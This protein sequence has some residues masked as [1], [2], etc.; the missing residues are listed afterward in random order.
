MKRCLLMSKKCRIFIGC[1][2]K[3]IEIAKKLRKALNE[4]N[5]ACSEIFDQG[6]FELSKTTIEN[7]EDNFPTFDM[8]VFLAFGDDL[9]LKKGEKKNIPRDNVVFEFGYTIALKGRERTI[10]LKDKNDKAELP[11]DLNG[12]TYFKLDEDEF[13]KVSQDIRTKYEKI[14]F[15]NRE[16]SAVEISSK[17]IY[18]NNDILF[19]LKKIYTHSYEFIAEMRLCIDN[20]CEN[21]TASKTDI[22]ITKIFFSKIIQYLYDI[23]FDNNYKINVFVA[24]ERFYEAVNFTSDLNEKIKIEKKLI[25]DSVINKEP[26]ILSLYNYKDVFIPDTYDTLIFTFPQSTELKDKLA[27]TI[28]VIDQKTYENEAYLNRFLAFAYFRMD[29]FFQHL[30]DMY[31]YKVGSLSEI[32]STIIKD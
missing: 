2:S 16:F 23:F 18:I 6:T 17:K 32:L 29:E 10:L 12:V 24:K 28:S 13:S 3:N 1:A 14:K 7:I 19:E 8:F 22:E 25:Q 21:K 30:F 27:I 5:W 11:S 15:T 4:D 9:I 31:T 20:L 26:I